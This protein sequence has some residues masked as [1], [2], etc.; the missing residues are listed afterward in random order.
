MLE[1]AAATRLGE[2]D[3]DVSFEVRAGACLAIAGPSGAGKTTLLRVVA[4]LAR[5]DRGRVA[6]GGEVWLDTARGV[7]LPPERRACGYL[8]Q[9]HALFGHLR[10]WQNVAYP[11]TA[12]RRPQRRA[13]AQELLERFAVGHLAERRPSSLSGGER[14]RVALARALAREPYVLLLDEPLSA[15]DARNRAGAARE[16]SAAIRDAGVPALLVTHEFDHAASISGEVGVMVAGRLLQRGAPSELAAKPTS[17][18]VADFTGRV[19]LTGIAR[20]GPN[21][22]TLVDLEGGG[23]VI[24]LEQATG[25]VMVSVYPWDVA[26]EPPAAP[27]LGSPRNRL[28]AEVTSLT[29][30]GSR[31]RLGLMAG[32]PLSAEISEA[33]ARDLALAPGVRVVATWKAAASRLVES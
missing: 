5:P 2:I 26:I 10:A 17:S 20:P 12:L 23:R 31:V 28:P 18:F 24:A 27:H 1:V 16:L 7:A 6:C 32:Q 4:G 21:G 9:D 13:R 11:L 19:V 22:A 14:Q 15:L 29:R 8:F 3:L 33:S 30:L 25:P